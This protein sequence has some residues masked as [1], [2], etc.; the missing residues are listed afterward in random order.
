MFCWNLLAC[1]F[2]SVTPNLLSVNGSF[3]QGLEAWESAFLPPVTAEALLLEGRTAVRLVVPPEATIGY[4]SVRQTYPATP[5]TV[6]S[7]YVEA[8]GTQVRDGAGV[9]MSV[10]FLNADGGRISFV[11][12]E[13]VIPDGSWRPLRIRGVAPPESVSAR[14]C[15]LLNGRGKACF[16]GVK[17]IATPGE[18]TSLPDGPVTL[19]VTDNI[20]CPSLKGFG[21]EDD[22][23]FYNEVNTAKG[24]TREDWVLRE[25][26]VRWMEPDWVR[27]FFWYKDWNPSGDWETFDFD[28]DNMRSHYQTLDLYQSIGAYVNVVGVE[29]GVPKFTDLPKIATAIGALFEHLLRVK[30]YSCVQEWTL[31]NEPNGSWT[32]RGNSFEEYVRLHELV[33]EE[34]RQRNLVLRILGSDDTSGLSWF[35]TCVRSDRYLDCADFFASHLYARYTDRHLAPFF[36]DD[37]LDL[38]RAHAPNRA[39]VIAEFGFQ[40]HRSGT[41][42]N[43]LMETYPYAIWTTAFVIKGLNQGI[44][45]FCIWCLHEVYYPGGGFMNYGLWN[46]KDRNWGVRPVYTAWANFTRH[47]QTGDVVYRC[48]SSAPGHVQATRVGDILFWVN[49]AERPV[50]VSIMGASP[51]RS[52]TYTES[53]LASDRECGIAWEGQKG[54]WTFPAESFGCIVVK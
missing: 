23:W 46:F 33:K 48:D 17:V 40:D 43:P 20:V 8:L 19:T 31:T 12:S 32:Q 3:E 38:L 39:M 30:G 47:T 2:L 24:V 50:E 44:A 22:G 51:V 45:G 41:L 18:E 14:L 34:F 28:S 49:E 21:A 9:Y 36:F 1:V 16:T 37:R 25:E 15:L 35:E 6:I 5:G 42:E 26:R 29:W 52:H 4:P 53:T 7:A 54:L 10:E 13:M 11:Q 27:M